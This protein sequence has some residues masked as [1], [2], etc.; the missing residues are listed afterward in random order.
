MTVR[1]EDFAIT[2]GKLDTNKCVARAQDDS[3]LTLGKDSGIF[4]KLRFLDNAVAC[5]ENKIVI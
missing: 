1:H 3:L 2:V 4:A 5:A